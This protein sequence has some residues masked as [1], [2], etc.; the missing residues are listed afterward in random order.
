[1]FSKKTIGIIIATAVASLG[2]AVVTYADNGTGSSTP[3]NTPSAVGQNGMNNAATGAVGNSVG[4]VNPTNLKPG[5]NVD[6]H[7]NG[8]EPGQTLGTGNS[9]SN[10]S[11]GTT[12]SGTI[13]GAQNSTSSGTDPNSNSTTDSTTTV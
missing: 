13:T 12:S 9:S 6:T 3:D 10:T 2:L 4:T 7:R 8:V 11:S 1:M 5:E